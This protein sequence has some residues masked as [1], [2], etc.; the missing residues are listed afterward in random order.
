MD[1]KFKVGIAEDCLRKEEARKKV[2]CCPPQPPLRSAPLLLRCGS[3]AA[4]EYRRTHVGLR[5]TVAEA[6]MLRAKPNRRIAMCAQTC[7]RDRRALASCGGMTGA[8]GAGG[9]G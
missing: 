8:G 9:R 2:Q 1:L 7:R 6:H 4:C 5:R 3:A